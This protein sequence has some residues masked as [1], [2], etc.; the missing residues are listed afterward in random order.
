[1]RVFRT[2]LLAGA[3]LL[4]ASLAPA[5]NY[6]EGLWNGKDRV[7]ND[8]SGHL[9][10]AEIHDRATSSM[11]IFQKGGWFVF[12]YDANRKRF[13]KVDGPDGIS[14]SY[15]FDRMGAPAGTTVHVGKLALSV[16]KGPDGRFEADGL[17]AIFAQTESHGRHARFVTEKGT[18]VASIDYSNK[19]YVQR[20]TID[21][22][23]KLELA[24]VAQRGVKQTLRDREGHVIQQV[25]VNK[26]DAADRSYGTNLDAVAGLF[27]LDQ[28]WSNVV[29]L[30][31]G[32]TGGLITI[33]K[34]G[35]PIG[36]VVSVQGGKVGFDANGT[37]L[38]YDLELQTVDVTSVVRGG[39]VV[40]SV[41]T[42]M[43]AVTPSNIVYTSDGRVGAYT[44]NVAFGAIF[45][46][47]T[48]GT[49]SRQQV[50]F[51]TLSAKPVAKNT[52]AAASATNVASARGRLRSDTTY[53]LCDTSTVCSGPTGGAQDCTT[54]YYY[55]PVDDSSGG[56]S[57]SGGGT[58]GGATGGNKVA[59]DGQ[60]YYAVNTGLTEAARRWNNNQPCPDLLASLRDRD[61]NLLAD[62]LA[63]KGVDFVTWMQQY[64]AWKNGTGT[65]YCSS[66][67][68]S[69]YVQIGARDAF[70]CPI[71]NTSMTVNQR[72]IRIIHE[73]LHTLGYSENPPDTN[74]PTS[75]EI[76]AMVASKCGGGA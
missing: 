12:H 37:P 15:D 47:W 67:V 5:Q 36:Y 33:K 4:G 25:I 65:A 2:S 52:N 40:D 34:S 73:T 58:R 3:L 53:V 13:N 29:T 66:G 42:E 60:L 48:E 61:G 20:V 26:G 44:A 68:N 64:V 16:K 72:A 71:F 10:Y 21:G 24:R 50:K 19:G 54:T 7:E 39:D 6:D 45:S 43:Q 18:Q 1:M 14:E 41:V 55:C 23:Y 76:N 32:A 46:F 69:L 22:G 8:P 57:P 63:A 28:N 74:M 70:V 27:G 38:Y 31:E 11:R 9:I 17:P 30:E 62:N 59:G 56:G 75:Q 51:R 35:V 49:A